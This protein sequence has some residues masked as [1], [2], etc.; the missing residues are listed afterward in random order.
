MTNFEVHKGRPDL[1]HAIFYNPL[2]DIV[3]FG[4]TGCHGTMKGVFDKEIVIPRV[5]INC[6]RDR[7]RCSNW[8]DREPS[9]SLANKYGSRLLEMYTLHEMERF[10]GGLRNPIGGSGCKGLKEIF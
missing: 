8:I 9:F 6:W 10:A 7:S 3:H 1:E 5:T 2:S 4:D